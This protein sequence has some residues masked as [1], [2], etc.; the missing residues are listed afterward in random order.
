MQSAAEVGTINQ[1]GIGSLNAAARTVFTLAIFTS[2][3]LLFAIQPMFTKMVLPQLGGSPAVWSVAMVFFQALLLIGYLYAHLST[4]YLSTRTA[5]AVHIGLLLITFSAMP[6]S[7]A[8]GL[9]NPPA[10]GQVFW[11]VGVFTFSVGLPFFAVAGNGPL[12]QA[13]FARTRHKDAGNPYFLYAASNLGSFAAL[14]LYP[15]A[16]ETTL[17]LPQQSMGWSYGFVVLALLIAASGYL[18]QKAKNDLL[19]DFTRVPSTVAPNARLI[20]KYIWLSF[21]PSALLVAVTAHISTDI[22]PAPFL[23]VVPLALYLLTFVL[24]FRDRPLVPARLVVHLVLI[25]AGLIILSDAVKF[26]IASSCLIHLGFFFTAALLHH[27]RLYDLRPPA[28]H[29]TQFYLWMSFGGVLGGIFSGLLAPNIFDRVLEYP[30]LIGLVLLAHPAVTHATR[31][32]LVRGVLPGLG[33]GAILLAGIYLFRDYEFIRSNSYQ[34]YLLAVLGIMIVCLYTQPLMR[35]ALILVALVIWEAPPAGILDTTFKRSFFGVHKIAIEEKG[36]FRT[37]SHGT[38]LHGA[39]RIRNPDG[40]DYVGPIRPATYYH[41]D[42]VLAQTLRWLPVRGTGRDLGVVGLGTGTH[43]CNGM[44]G[45]RWS[46]FE[47][48]PVVVKIAT[49]PTLFSFLSTCAPTAKIILGDARLTLAEQPPATLDYLL[50]DAFSSDTI[51][52]HL[53]TREAIALYMSRLRDDG[54]LAIHISNRHLELGSVVA[55]LAKDAG[56]SV[57]LR[58]L[59]IKPTSLGDAVPSSAAVFAR[60]PET[61]AAFTEEGGWKQPATNN[62][63]VWTDDY[64]NILGAI[65]RKYAN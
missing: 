44:S 46:Y 29:L 35:A 60:R 38:T 45:D 41:A 28:E 12:L 37:L 52:I 10:E 13:W 65:W 50:V 22:A 62:V 16:F 55:S 31:S 18:M 36:Q 14:L 56:L 24:I 42:G 26:N 3:F 15:L 30:I 7:I 25:F 6:I 9:G 51:P 49:D 5:I 1:T 61:L 32:A 63:P 43:A 20:S 54:L 64:S 4:R 53:M 58:N 40:T 33:L 39:M 8:S 17:R 59:V 11:L 57:K 21:V 34:K 47:I 27:Q 23:W 48:D 2:A 19:E